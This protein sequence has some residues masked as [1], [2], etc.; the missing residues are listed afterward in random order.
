MAASV[1]ALFVPAFVS[2]V[3][4]GEPSPTFSYSVS[5]CPASIETRPGASWERE[6]GVL[7][8]T[9]ANPRPDVGVG[10][11]IIS[12]TAEGGDITEITTQGTL[13][14]TVADDPPGL[15]LEGSDGF[16][17]TTTGV[18]GGSGDCAGRKGTVSMVQLSQFVTPPVTLPPEGPA[19]VA[20]IKVAG[21]APAEAGE[22]PPVRIFFVDF[23]RGLG[24]PV[25]N[26]IDWNGD[27]WRPLMPSCDFEVVASE[28]RFRRGDANGDGAVNI[29]DAIAILGCKFAGETC[30]SCRDAADVNDDG[31]DNIT[32]PIRLLNHLF[33]G[34]G[35]LPLPGPTDCGVDPAADALAPCVYDRCGG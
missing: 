6:G 35:G 31:T 27:V 8:T 32:D 11:W 23:C 13:A 7:L 9:T 3:S 16:E 4:A 2:L 30:P 29:T 21:A 12:M 17:R 20:R 5:P 24:M 19:L 1:L 14:A 26:A 18:T 34:D 33:I 28:P 15:R 22:R 10:G 25:Q